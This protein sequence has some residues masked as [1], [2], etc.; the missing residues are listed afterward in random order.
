MTRKGFSLY[1][2]GSTFVVQEDRLVYDE[3]SGQVYSEPAYHSQLLVFVGIGKEGC[4]QLVTTWLTFYG[5]PDL[6]TAGLEEVE[7]LFDP[8]AKALTAPPVHDDKDVN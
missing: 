5:D 7:N 2:N 8:P 1:R 4:K 3:A 6:V